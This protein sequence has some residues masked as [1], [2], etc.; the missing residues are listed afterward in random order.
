MQRHLQQMA[1]I[2]CQLYQA[3]HILQE[4]TIRYYSVIESHF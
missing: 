2:F 1:L 4:T 3:H